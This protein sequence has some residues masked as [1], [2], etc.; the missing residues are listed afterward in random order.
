MIFRLIVTHVILMQGLVVFAQTQK[1]DSVSQKKEKIKKGW[2]FGAVPAIAFD[3]DIGI[4]YGIVSNFYHYGDGTLYPRYKHSIYLEWSRTTKGSGIN[5]LKYDSEFLIPNIRFNAEAGY[6]TEQALYFYGFNGYEAYYNPGF[7]TKGSADYISKMYYRIDRKLTRL[8]FD[9]QGNIR[10]R[11]LR[12]LL[13]YTFFNNKIGRVDIN[14]LNKGRSQNDQLKDTTLLYDKYVQWGIIPADQKNGGVTHFLKAG[15]IY[16]TRDNEP[17]PMKGIWTEIMVWSAPSF[18]DNKF[19]F[20]K[21]IVTHR[22]YFTLK[23]EVLNFAYRVSYQGKISGE[24]PF[25]MLPFVYNS[26]VIRD[27]LGGAKTLRGVLRNRVVGDNIAF[28][29]F[30]IRWKFLRFTRFNQNFYGAVS[31]F[32]DAGRVLGKYKFSTS[33]SEA[34]AYLNHG[35]AETWHQTYGVG[36]YGAMNQNFVVSLNYGLAADARDGTSGLYI[37]LDF[38]Y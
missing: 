34:I 16:D 38:L 1:T 28:A 11:G 24:M 22:Q 8:K 31:A 33:N 10:G 15:V 14:A 35:S 6:F 27:G 26:T 32:T 29:N 4:Q 7:E 5:L 3:T 30:E 13:G 19:S 21:L 12:W 23:K 2:N 25:Y 36:L 9:F 20:T 17:N 37:G 18:L